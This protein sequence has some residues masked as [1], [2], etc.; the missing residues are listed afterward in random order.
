MATP[1]EE[2]EEGEEALS[3]SHSLETVS[4][5]SSRCLFSLAHARARLLFFSSSRGG[6]RTRT[7]EK[8]KR[9][10]K[11]SIVVLA[12]WFFF[13]RSLS[14]SFH[15]HSGRKKGKEVKTSAFFSFLS[16]FFS[17]HFET[18]PA[19]LASFSSRWARTVLLLLLLL[20]R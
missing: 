4:G 19:P 16:F 13:F 3:P 8:E 14:L 9:K 18:C 17:S 1:N 15:K 12:H 6:G 2:A 7:G 11:E 20:L 5:T 10:G